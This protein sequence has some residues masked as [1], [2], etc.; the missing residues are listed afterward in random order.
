MKQI[1]TLLLLTFGVL[2]FG[3]LR[4]NGQE[5]TEKKHKLKFLFVERIRLTNMDQSVPLDPKSEPKAVTS[6]RTYLGAKYQYGNNFSILAQMGNIAAFWFAPSSKK[7]GL[8][9]IFVNQLYVDWKNIGNSKL[10]VTLGRQNIA[11]DEG[12]ICFDAQPLTGSRS[13]AFNAIRADYHLND[14]RSITAFFAYNPKTDNL[15]PIINEGEKPKKLEEQSNRG[16][17]VYYQSYWKPESK[18]SLYYFHKYSFCNSKFPIKLKRHAVGGRLASGFADYWKIIAEAAYQFGKT[19]EEQHSAYGGYLKLSRKFQDI[20]ILRKLLVGS[21]YY[22]GDDANSSKTEG[23]DPL[24]S[25]YPKWSTSYVYTLAK[26][27]GGKVAYW[28]NM[29]SVYLSLNGQIAP[30]V[31]F[32]SKYYYLMSPKDNP[33]DFCSG[34]GKHRGNLWVLKVKYKI[35]EHFAGYFQWENFNVGDFYHKEAEGYNFA[36][37]QLLYKF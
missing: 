22:S 5:Q 19:G 23:W 15:L 31:S 35:D 37:F 28:T 29:S 3:V 13:M 34:G 18:L 33:I 6:W 20:P 12:F 36:R 8:N 7:T 26:E 25:R 16:L 32:V 4:V 1:L 9:E 10:D 2:N 24:W 14:K 11:L 27:N 30:R 17:G 21:F